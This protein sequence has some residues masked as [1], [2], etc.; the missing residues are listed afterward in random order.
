MSEFENVP[1]LNEFD[2]VGEHDQKFWRARGVA[3]G[4]CRC[5]VGVGLDAKVAPWDCCVH[6]DATDEPLPYVPFQRWLV[7]VR[8]PPSLFASTSY[9]VLAD[10][11][12]GAADLVEG[13][14]KSQDLP[15]SVA[16]V[17]P[18]GTWD[19]RVCATLGDTTPA[20]TVWDE[21]KAPGA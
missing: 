8:E 6:G 12:E 3:A 21:R 4:L 10:T 17:Q 5:V 9:V 2:N 1:W 7:S 11:A 18:A 16:R 19:A 14:R 13:F 15:A 20:A